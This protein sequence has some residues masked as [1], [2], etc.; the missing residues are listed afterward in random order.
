QNISEMATSVKANTE[1]AERIARKFRM[2]NTTGYSLN[3][4]INCTDLMSFI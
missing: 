2:K 4:L 1:L 3:A